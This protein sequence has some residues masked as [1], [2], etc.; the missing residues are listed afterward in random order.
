MDLEFTIDSRVYDD[1]V[2]LYTIFNNS[3]TATF[4]TI[5]DVVYG[6]IQTI[7]KTI[8]DSTKQ[9]IPGETHIDTI[10]FTK[11]DDSYYLM[12]SCTMGEESFITPIYDVLTEEQYKYMVSSLYYITLD[13]C[14]NYVFYNIMGT[15]PTDEL[16]T[17]AILMLVP[18]YYKDGNRVS[19]ISNSI[20]TFGLFEG[21]YEY[22]ENDLITEAHSTMNMIFNDI[23]YE[24]F[25]TD[26]Q[27]KYTVCEF[28]EVTEIDDSYEAQYVSEP[29]VPL[30]PLDDELFLQ[31]L[32]CIS[33]GIYATMRTYNRAA[34]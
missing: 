1:S 4:K 27:I 19:Y 6:K 5:D 14:V 25:V 29:T 16:L 33:N 26:C 20:K 32:L 12:F 11:I 21:Y 34:C 15:V 31:D 3:I 17:Q 2:S 7:E 23:L 18:T 13:A 9:V 22:N 28:N 10:D 8:D 24:S 30:Y